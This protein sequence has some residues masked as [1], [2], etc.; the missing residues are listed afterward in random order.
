MTAELTPEPPPLVQRL[1]ENVHT[2]LFRKGWLQKD[3]AAAI[4]VSPPSVSRKLKNLNDWTVPEVSAI[5]EETHV[6]VAELLGNLP[7][8]DT[9]RARRDSNSQPSDP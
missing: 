1:N 8:F 2:L 7:D 5:A 6:E 3:L 4:D 9:W